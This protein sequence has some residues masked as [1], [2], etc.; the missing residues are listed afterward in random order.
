MIWAHKANLRPG[1]R[2]LKRL[3]TRR[4]LLLDHWRSLIAR[5]REVYGGKLTYAAN[6]DHYPQVGFWT[7]LD[8]VGINSYFT[9]RPHLDDE[10]GDD[11]LLARFTDAWREILDGVETLRGDKPVIF[12]EIGYT[13]RRY[14]TVEPWNHGGFTVVG[15]KGHDRKLVV[16]NEQPI[17]RGERPCSRRPAKDRICCVGCSTGSS[18]PTPGT[19]RSSRSCS[20]SATTAATPRSRC[21]VGS[22]NP[23]PSGR[24]ASAA[25]AEASARRS[26]SAGSSSTPRATSR[27]PSRAT[28]RDPSRPTPNGR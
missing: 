28:D 13:F 23:R 10:P 19:R 4:R 27:S 12:T 25:S 8:Y 15:W 7:E 17:D 14:S 9:L 21:S 20:T 24:P 3:N 16:W 5:T 26:P 2:T 22:L 1:G 6:F 18:A 11:A